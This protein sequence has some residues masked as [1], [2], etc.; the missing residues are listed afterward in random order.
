[1]SLHSCLFPPIKSVK[2]MPSHWSCSTIHYVIEILSYT[3]SSTAMCLHPLICAYQS[4]VTVVPGV[5]VYQRG[6][7]SHACYLIAVIPPR[8]D[9][10]VLVR[11]LPQPVIC[12]T[13][14]I[15][16]VPWPVSLIK[17]KKNHLQIPLN[18]PLSIRYI[19]R[20]YL[21]LTSVLTASSDISSVHLLFVLEY[22][23]L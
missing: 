23:I 18:S 4:Y 16:N 5:V 13:E 22:I 15:Q 9:P 19:N 10:C 12:L 2:M 3:I 20:T 14:I 11:V 1:M 21:H 6:P 7:V 17:K 8:H